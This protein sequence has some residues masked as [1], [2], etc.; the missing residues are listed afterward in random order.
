MFPDYLFHHALLR[1]DSRHPHHRNSTEV[2]QRTGNFNGHA[3]LATRA[4]ISTHAWTAN[5]CDGGAGSAGGAGSGNTGGAGGVNDSRGDQN[6]GANAVGGA[7]SGNGGGGGSVGTG[8]A[9][10]SGGGS[11]SSGGATGG[12]SPGTINFVRVCALQFLLVSD[13]NAK[14]YSALA[15]VS[16]NLCL[17]AS[18]LDTG[19]ITI[20]RATYHAAHHWYNAGHVADIQWTIVNDTATMNSFVFLG[21]QRFRAGLS[22]GVGTSTNH[23][24]GE[25]ASVD[26]YVALEFER[27]GLVPAV[28]A[29]ISIV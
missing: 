27:A 26:A 10:G 6:G 4:S 25:S 24:P 13:V 21:D 22:V 7:D 19:N 1:H 11:P 3:I 20:S 14:S 28:G 23:V 8:G 2:Q 17:T 18:G 9:A 15:D 5:T 16:T 29:E 12:N